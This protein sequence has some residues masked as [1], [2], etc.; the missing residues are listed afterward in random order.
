MHHQSAVRD[1]PDSP[2]VSYSF[3]TVYLK[4]QAEAE[5]TI[6]LAAQSELRRL[7]VEKMGTKASVDVNMCIL[8]FNTKRSYKK[9]KKKKKGYKFLHGV[10]M[11]CVGLL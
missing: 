3:I 5:E 6:L 2:E 7:S 8:M 4:A 11:G 10:D 1:A 9:V